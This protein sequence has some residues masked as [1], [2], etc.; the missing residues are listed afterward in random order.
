MGT[1][2][3][4][5]GRRHEAGRRELDRRTGVGVAAVLEV[6]HA[7]RPARQKPRVGLGALPTRCSLPDEFCIGQIQPALV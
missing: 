6:A 4:R 2:S 7:D 3:N 1:A 5:H